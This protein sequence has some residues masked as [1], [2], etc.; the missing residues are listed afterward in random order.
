MAIGTAGLTSMLCV[1][2][3][4]RH[5]LPDKAKVVVTGASGGV[6]SIAVKL[7][8]DQGHHVAALTGRRE[9]EPF[10]RALGAVE[11]VDRANYQAASKPLAAER[12]NAAVDTVGGAV[13]ANVIASMAY[14]G[15]VAACGLAGGTD[16]PTSVFPFIL[17]DVALLGVDS[18][19]SS[20]AKRQHAWNRLATALTEADLAEVT[21]EVALEDVLSLADKILKGHVRGRQVVRVLGPT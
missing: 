5:G 15:A 9:E 16:L 10:L 21:G 6:G 12:W 1:A 18:V 4:E 2:A 14:G 3:L 7:L 17:R 20:M 19:Q 11:I 13:L 8:A